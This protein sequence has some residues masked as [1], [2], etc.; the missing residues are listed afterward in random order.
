MNRALALW[1]APPDIVPSAFVSRVLR[2]ALFGCLLLLSASR[3]AGQTPMQVLQQTAA[4]YRKLASYEFQVTVQ[5]KRGTDVSE[6]RLIEMGTR[7]GKFRVE[8][9]DSKGELRVADGQ[10]QW[11][12]NRA[13]NEYSRAPVTAETPT[14]IS[15]L[16]N[17]DQHVSDAGF[18]REELF[19]VGGKPV[20]IV[21]VRVIRD[22]GPQGT[23]NGAQFVMYRIDESNFRVYKAITYYE[24]E[25]Q[26]V[27]YSILKWNQPVPE[28]SYAFKP[29][30]SS[31]AA[32]TGQEQS[33]PFRSLV[34][35]QAP[36]FTLQDANGRT[37]SLHA[38]L[39]KVVI[40]EFWASWCGP[41]REQMP[42]LQRMSRESERQ[43]LVVLGLNVGE[44]A[45]AV[46]QFAHEE[47]YTFPLLLGAEPEISAKY[48]VEV[49]PTTFVIDRQGR[50]SFS[51]TGLEPP[52]RLRSAVASALG[53]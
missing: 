6:Q 36:D 21:V 34:G 47:S 19:T 12:F 18:M 10:D 1:S 39:G 26:I 40:V 43:G 29:P 49:Y 2:I 3:A 31:R 16:E 11:V 38:L 53:Q 23:P 35:T 7:P 44:P 42:E 9:A 52:D 32:S 46:E 20:R 8:S 37:V 48:F 51:S 22:V 41:C 17:I 25:T 28:S 45:N 27:L 33:I 50:I 14:P 5:T 24:H 13:S 4:V 15:D 30:P